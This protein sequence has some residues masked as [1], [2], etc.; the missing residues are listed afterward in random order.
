QRA[1]NA[2]SCLC[3][4]V[5]GLFCGNSK[6]NPAC[7]TGDVFQCNESGSTCDFGVRDSCHNCNEL[8]C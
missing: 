1:C 3:N 8:V 5:P 4:G 7:K 2:S 6:I